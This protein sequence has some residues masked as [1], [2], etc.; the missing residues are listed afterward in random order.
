MI[1]WTGDG[2]VRW[3][4][5]PDDPAD[6]LSMSVLEAILDRD[7]QRRAEEAEK[8]KEIEKE[9]ETEGEGE[10]EGDDGDGGD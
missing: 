3:Q 6:P 8:A 5:F 7:D 1:L 2:I 4:G 9:K 10:G